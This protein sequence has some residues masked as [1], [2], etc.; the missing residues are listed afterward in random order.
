[1]TKLFGDNYA[2]TDST[3]VEFGMPPRQFQ[4]FMQAADEATISRMYGGIHYMPAC[5]NGKVQGRKVGEF[6]LAKIKTR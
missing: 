1:M 2:F 3:E 6:V 4:S 5:N